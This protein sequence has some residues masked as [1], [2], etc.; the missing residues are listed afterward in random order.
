MVLQN[1]F[2]LHYNLKGVKM[3]GQIFT[4]NSS[5]KIFQ[6]IRFHNNLLFNN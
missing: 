2:S 5:Q 4:E 6:K 3:I 1:Y